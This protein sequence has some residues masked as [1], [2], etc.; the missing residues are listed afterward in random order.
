VQHSQQNIHT[1]QIWKWRG[2]LT[3]GWKHVVLSNVARRDE[4]TNT[5]RTRL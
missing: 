1:K 4:A 5:K 2:G 3:C